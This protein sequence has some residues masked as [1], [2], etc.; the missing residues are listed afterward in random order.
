M[1]KRYSPIHVREPLSTAKRLPLGG[2]LSEPSG[3][4]CPSP[5]CAKRSKG[6]A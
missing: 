5:M 4:A 2:N 6:G 3:S 1:K